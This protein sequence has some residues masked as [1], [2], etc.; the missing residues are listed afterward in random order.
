LENEQQRNKATKTDWE[1]EI[2]GE[3]LFTCR[4]KGFTEGNH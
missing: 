4:V 2:G 1:A 3:F